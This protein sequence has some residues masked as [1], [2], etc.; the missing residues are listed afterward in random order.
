MKNLLSVLATGVILA[1]TAQ[2]EEAKTAAKAA[3]AKPVAAASGEGK[4]A[5]PS[6]A[7]PITAHAKET[8]A[9]KP[10]RD[11]PNAIRSWDLESSP[12]INVRLHEITGTVP[13]HIHNDAQE[14][15]FLVEGEVVMTVG[16]Q[17]FTMKPGDYVSIP[18]GVQ[19]KVEL[20]KGKKRALAA[21]FTI[22]SPDPKQTTWVEPAPQPAASK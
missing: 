10:T 4:P 1:S 6:E 5:A 8:L 20:A 22:P 9:S 21:G 7:K 19:H 2:A 11:F 13:M 17:K 12:D 15:V 14:R 16:D 18:K 3:E